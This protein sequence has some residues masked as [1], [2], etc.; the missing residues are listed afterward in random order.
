MSRNINHYYSGRKEGS[1]EIIIH[2]I[3]DYDKK[4]AL[5]SLWTPE[6][7]SSPSSPSSVCSSAISTIPKNSSSLGGE[8]ISVWG[9]GDVQ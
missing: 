5:I 2:Y 4:E 6:E 3:I 8:D 1:E 9:K 7:L